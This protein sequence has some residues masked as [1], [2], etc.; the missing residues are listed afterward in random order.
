MV[1]ILSPFSGFLGTGGAYTYD[2]FPSNIR[3]EEE[4]EKRKQT[5][6]AASGLSARYKSHAIVDEYHSLCIIVVFSQS[7][8]FA[9][10]L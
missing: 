4:E 3:T 8:N 5:L 1:F 10:E 9:L 6:A 2:R 7:G